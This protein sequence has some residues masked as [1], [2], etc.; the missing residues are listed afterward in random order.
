LDQVARRASAAL[1]RVE[2]SG[3][4]GFGL[5]A[6]LAAF[7]AALAGAYVLVPPESLR[8]RR[9]ALLAAMSRRGLRR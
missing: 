9:L 5:A 4:S 3:G 2:P 8:R 6:M 1:P 7:A